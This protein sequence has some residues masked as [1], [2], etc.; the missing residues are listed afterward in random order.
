MDV[1]V[2]ESSIF[3]VAGVCKIVIVDGSVVVVLLITV[4]TSFALLLLETVGE[5]GNQ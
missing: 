2:S 1:F 5:C 3:F 4:E